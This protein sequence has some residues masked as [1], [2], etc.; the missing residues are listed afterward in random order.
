[1][2]ERTL[3]PGELNLYTGRTCER[4]LDGKWI[5]YERARVKDL[6]E[7]TGWESLGALIDESLKTPYYSRPHPFLSDS[8]REEMRREICQTDKAI[9]A[10]AFLTGARIS[11]VLMAHAD[12][13]SVEGDFIICKDLP[14]LKRFSK[15]ASEVEYLDKP[16]AGEIV[17]SGYVWSKTYGAFVKIKWVTEAKIETREDF[18]IPLWE[19]FT[20]TLMERIRDAKPGPGGFRWL[21]PSSMVPGRVESKGVQRWI[22]ERFSLEARAWLSPERAYQKVRTIGERRGLHIF[23]HWFRS[24]RASMLNRYYRFN[25]QLLTRF[26]SWAGGWATSQPSMAALYARTGLEELTEKMQANKT[27]LLNE[28]K[29]MKLD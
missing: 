23:D 4:G 20:D 13:F 22:L 25:E 21:F 15:I 10:T 9:Q 8:Y 28:L 2:T 19:P 18:P 7:F 14:V 26:F 24:Q 12:N 29:E 3:E 5:H 17:P 27:R 6:K 16:N 1:M 11:E